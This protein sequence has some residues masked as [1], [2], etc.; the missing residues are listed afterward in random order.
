[1]FS[2][3]LHRAA[4]ALFA[5]ST[6]AAATPVLAADAWKPTKPV[7]LLVGFAP[8]GSADLLA[9]ML[10]E[11]LSQRLG[12]PVV[13]ENLAGAGGNIMAYRLSQSANDGYAI[14]IAAA[15]SM[16]ITH[17]L[18]PKG[19]N[20]KPADFTPITLVATQ[21]NVVIVNK[22]VPANT[23]P[24]LKEYFQKTPTATYGTAGVGISN[25]LIAETM[26][27]KLGVKV[28]HAAYRGAAPV[29]TDL[30]GGHIAMTMD[31]ISTAA[32]LVQQGKVKAIGVASIKRAPQL[33]N[34]PTLDEQGLTGF[35]MPTWQGVFAPAGLPA[36]ARET[37][38]AALQDVLK[39]PALIEK[40]AT[41]GSEPVTGMS[42]AQF[43]EFL[44]KD[45]QQWADIVKAANISLEQ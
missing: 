24:E 3:T 15:G 4:G 9:R 6:L 44:E 33:P 10:A 40:M 34:V 26:L 45:R 23:L 17:V 28:P 32:P 13:V 22:D 39:Q 30:L 20:Y 42:S 18:N 38:Y 37:Y 2:R 41:L 19:T 11:P 5:A 16:A 7:R 36:E 1:M 12:Q 35:N 27:Y 31:N 43:G 8:G 21:P 25:H 29:I 14:G